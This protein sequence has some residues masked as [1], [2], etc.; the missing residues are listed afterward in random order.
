MNIELPVQ[1]LPDEFYLTMFLFVTG[2]AAY[3]L[4]HPAT[5]L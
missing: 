1:T 4:G 3:M 2:T 5:A